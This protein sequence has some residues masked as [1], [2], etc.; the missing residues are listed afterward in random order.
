MV[1]MLSAILLLKN[2]AHDFPLPH[3]KKATPTIHQPKAWPPSP[4]KSTHSLRSPRSGMVALRH[5]VTRAVP[6]QVTILLWNN[7]YVIDQN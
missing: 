2:T 7:W 4:E 3:A 6:Y 1:W 5:T